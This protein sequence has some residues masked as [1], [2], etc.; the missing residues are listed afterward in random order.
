M[1]AGPTQKSPGLLHQ[2]PPVRNCFILHARDCRRAD[3]GGRP[4][5]STTPTG[6]QC[7]APRMRDSLSMWYTAAPEVISVL[8]L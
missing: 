5:S 1:S 6:A 8:H 4:V 2:L 3:A 7:S